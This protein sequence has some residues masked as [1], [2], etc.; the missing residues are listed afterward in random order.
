MRQPIPAQAGDHTRT[1]ATPAH[2]QRGVDDQRHDAHVQRRV[3]EVI[4]ASPRMA[5]QRAQAAAIGRRPPSPGGAISTHAPVQARF[6]F[7][8]ELPLL[9]VEKA[10]VN[11]P[12]L[13]GGAALPMNDVPVDAGMLGGATDLVAGP[14]C[15]VNA[16]HSKTLNKLFSADLDQ[17]AVDNALNANGAASLHALEGQLMPHGASIVEVVTD[18]WDESALTRPQA[19]QHIQDV[20]DYVNAM[21][22]SVNGNRQ[23]ALGGYFIG[24][25]SPQSDAFQ[26]RLGY[27]H[28]TY[29]VKLSQV[30]ALFQETTRQKS[31]LN[32]YVRNNA[33]Q[34]EHADNVQATFDSIGAAKRAMS[35]IKDAWP[36]TGANLVTRGTK[37]WPAGAEA[38]FL[39]FL[40]LLTNY[41]AMFAANNGAN[42]AKQM[43]GMHYY[44]S[45]LYDVAQT[46]PNEVIGTLSANAP[47]LAQTI[48]AIGAETGFGA[49]A[50]LGGPMGNITLTQYLEQIFTGN[51]GIILQR[52]GDDFHDELLAGSINPYSRKLGPDL[53]GPAAHQAQGVVLENR[54]LEYLNPNYGDQQDASEDQIAQDAVQYGPP[55]AGPDNR[56]ADERAMYDSI[57]A[58]EA[59]PARRPINEWAEIMIGIYDMVKRLNR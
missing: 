55:K 49:G 1:A 59:G 6:G 36:R 25:D 28:A 31:R 54:H 33:P 35:T 29:G 18:A 53:L 51:Q 45:D 57:G 16:D 11:V 9:F 23:A 39:G 2:A 5:A 30:P 3:G 10:N 46:L 47:L 42:L 24:S 34:K 21:Y 37:G 40:T 15:H 44:K 19:L 43:V 52:N 58:R 27:F 41:L 14:G 38:S 13:A 50:A 17:Y 22:D 32:R 20:I 7:E 56:T 48:A 8:V 26:P 4:A 12:S